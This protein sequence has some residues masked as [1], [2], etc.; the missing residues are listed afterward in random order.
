MPQEPSPQE[1]VERLE[2]LFSHHQHMVQ[3]LNEVIVQ[4]RTDVE[5]LKARAARYEARLQQVADK[6]ASLDDQPDEKPP[7]Y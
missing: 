2:E 7:H 3:Q 1:R 6:Q 4:L 5:N